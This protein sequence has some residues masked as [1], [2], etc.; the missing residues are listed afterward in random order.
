MLVKYV[1]LLAEILGA[2][3]D[4]ENISKLAGGKSFPNREVLAKEISKKLEG[5]DP[6]KCFLM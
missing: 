1:K 2:Y 3:F 5:A 4:P 6:R